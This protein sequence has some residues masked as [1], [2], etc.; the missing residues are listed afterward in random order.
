MTLGSHRIKTK[1]NSVQVLINAQIVD[2]G[3]GNLAGKATRPGL[4]QSRDHSYNGERGETLSWLNLAENPQAVSSL[5]D[6]APS[7][8]NVEIFT[9]KIDRDG[10]TA[11]LTIALNE[12]PASPP[13]RW[14]RQQAN[15]VIMTLQLI[16]LG[17]IDV[18][19][20]STTN[21]AEIR[22]T[23]INAETLELVANGA[24]LTVRATFG[25]LRIAGLSAYHFSPD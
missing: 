5:F 2:F 25:F 6:T 14:R 3:A 11:E 13:L 21:S 4:S 17:E 16:A 10:P 7:L 22:I 15:R 8:Q 20:W 19:G 18:K 1:E 12:Y 23:R 9:F 24:N